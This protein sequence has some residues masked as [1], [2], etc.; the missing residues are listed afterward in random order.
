MIKEKAKDHSKYMRTT[1]HH[2]LTHLHQHHPPM[3]NW[4]KVLIGL[5]IGVV[6]AII[7][8]GFGF[9]LELA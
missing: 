4:K 8:A 7:I 9:A 5:G 2:N 1:T 6:V 3:N